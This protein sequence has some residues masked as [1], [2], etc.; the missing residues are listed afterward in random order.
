ML[1]NDESPSLSKPGA[2]QR[3]FTF[4]ANLLYRSQ[5]DRRS[6]TCRNKFCFWM[7]EKFPYC[8][9]RHF[10]FIMKLFRCLQIQVHV[11]M[12]ASNINCIRKYWN[13]KRFT[14]IFAV[15]INALPWNSLHMSSMKLVKMLCFMGTD[16]LQK[17]QYICLHVVISPWNAKHLLKFFSLLL[18]VN[19]VTLSFTDFAIESDT[20]NCTKDFVEILDGN[21]YEAPL[22]GTVTLS[23]LFHI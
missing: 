18:P 8:I 6:Q 16:W 22:R 9:C 5:R 20:Q 7:C 12:H 13:M 2:G 1:Q 19:H 21:N 11:Y 4:C 14:R 17:R 15:R 3:Q 23:C 10:Q